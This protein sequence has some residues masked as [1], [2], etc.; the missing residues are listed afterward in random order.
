MTNS[1]VLFIVFNRP[2]TTARILEKII[3]AK[4]SKIYVS[5]DG[6]RTGKEQKQTEETRKLVENM[7]E[8]VNCD[9]LWRHNNLG[10][11]KGV[12]SAIDWFFDNEVEG[13]ILED[14]CLPHSDFFQFCDLALKKFRNN[15]SV[16]HIAGSN[17]L[18]KGGEPGNAAYFSRL[19]NIWG[20][21]TWRRAWKKYDPEMTQFDDF[22][23]GT[24]LKDIVSDSALRSRYSKLFRKIYN[25]VDTWDFQW[26]YSNIIHKGLSIIP[27]SNLITNIGFG[28]NATHSIDPNNPLA[29]LPLEQLSSWEIPNELRPDKE[30]EKKF[31]EITNKIPPLYLRILNK[32]KK[33]RHLIASGT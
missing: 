32:I 12:I 29:N 10:C 25:G 27:N 22:I 16:M 7:T 6:P 15:D 11:K 4:P 26:T 5:G 2:D 13:I 30:A 14:D 3:E 31:L 17:L 33:I 18:I 9:F 24:S 20:W 1:P 28:N 8:N 19:P 21:A 23:S